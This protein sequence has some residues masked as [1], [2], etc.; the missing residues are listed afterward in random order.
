MNSYFFIPASKIS[1]LSKISALGNQQI[2]IDFEDA[3]TN[4][5]RIEL[6]DSIYSIPDFETYW[7]RV[8]L[9]DSYDEAINS[10]YMYNLVKGGIKKIILPKIKNRNELSE[11]VNNPYFSHLDFIVLIE[12]PL[13]LLEIEA[14]FYDE[15]KAKRIYGLGLGSFDLI[16]ELHANY[17]L[18]T[19]S[20]PRQKLKYIATAYNKVA[21]DI[22]SMD[23]LDHDSFI[24]ELSSGINLG[25]DAKFI[26]HPIQ[27]EW[28]S[29]Y[30][31]Q[32]P[33]LI[34]AKIVL[35]KL[36]E[37]EVHNN[38]QPFKIDGKIIEKPHIQRA[39]N[40]LEKY[41]NYGE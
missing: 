11:I 9:R 34:W 29:D 5:Q 6:K 14:F 30:I 27:Y 24:N 10:D 16:N 8:P 15:N 31:K 41:K 12:H 32:L 38:H 28:L 39:F 18:E 21:I 17:S 4:Q 7:Y 13:L 40:L 36:P 35:S 26:I 25:Y 37:G 3:I 23:V 1:K 22:A 20:Y 33:E 19:L 2:I